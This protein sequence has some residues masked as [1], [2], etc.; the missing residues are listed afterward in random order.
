VF[1]GFCAPERSGKT[2]PNAIL[3]TRPGHRLQRWQ[4][5]GRLTAISITVAES[6]ARQDRSGRTSNRR[7]LQRNEKGTLALVQRVRQREQ[8]HGNADGHSLPI[9]VY[10]ASALANKT[11]LVEGYLAELLCAR[12]RKRPSGDSA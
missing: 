9:A 12:L 3:R 1:S 2:C 7:F 8:D 10:M 4:R 5:S 11:K 6:G